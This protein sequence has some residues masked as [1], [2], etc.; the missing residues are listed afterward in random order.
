MTYY[1]ISALVNFSIGL[2]LGFFVL[3]KNYKNK[4]NIGFFIF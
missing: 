3:Y 2:L 1:S 4:L